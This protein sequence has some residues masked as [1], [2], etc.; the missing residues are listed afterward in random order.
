MRF[1]RASAGKIALGSDGAGPM[2]DGGVSIEAPWALRG[3]YLESE[4]WDRQAGRE[5]ARLHGRSLLH[6]E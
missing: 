5:N 1:M 6:Q 4:G 3:P 2:V